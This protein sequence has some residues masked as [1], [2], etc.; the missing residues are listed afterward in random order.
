MEGK[1]VRGR[2]Y[3]IRKHETTGQKSGSRRIPRT[4]RVQ[5]DIC[6]GMT[7]G[8]LNYRL[9]EGQLSARVMEISS[10][11]VKEKTTHPGEELLFCLTGT[12][13]ILIC[14]VT[15]V[16]KKGD[17]IFFWGA[18][19]HCYFNADDKK[20]VSVALSVVCGEN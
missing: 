13:G 5:K 7:I 9:P 18:E 1:L 6:H 15:A 8:D 19:P 3:D 20:E 17:A 14:D 16:L 10:R 12:V 4:D 2:D 11:E